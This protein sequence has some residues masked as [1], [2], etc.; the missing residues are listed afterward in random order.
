MTPYLFGRVMCG[1]LIVTSSELTAVKGPAQL[2]FAFLCFLFQ[3]WLGIYSKVS[4]ISTVRINVKALY[5]LDCTV[6]INFMTNS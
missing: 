4:I 1:I 2:Y 6:R 5:F 3:L